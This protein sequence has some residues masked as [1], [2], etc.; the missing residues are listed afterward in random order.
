VGIA[1][2]HTLGL[3]AMEVQF[4][5]RVGMGA[6]TAKRVRDAACEHH[7]TLSAHAPY[8]INLNSKDPA[9]LAESKR[10]LLA[11]ARMAALCGARNVVF[12]VAFY[13]GDSPDQVYQC[14]KG[15]VE[16]VSQ[17]LQSEGVT[18]CLRP[19]TSGRLSQFGTLDEIL[20]LSAEVAGVRPCVDFG[21]LHAHAAGAMNTYDEFASVFEQ[22][23]A[24][25]GSVAL[26]DMHLHVQ[27]MAYGPAGEQ[28]HLT[29]GESDMRYEQLL[30]AA[31][32]W[33]VGGTLICESPNLEEDALLLMD[34]YRELS[35]CAAEAAVSES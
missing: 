24:C 30:Q 5:R 4:V 12:H 25:L 20:R 29:L 10:R 11:A 28:R 31:L 7:V 21:H 8:Y 14:V 13:H 23:K 16:E 22:V 6:L 1:R 3:G 18:V 17:R 27:G 33:Q 26:Q 9:K 32:D 19:E 35:G 15:G 2:V 34:T